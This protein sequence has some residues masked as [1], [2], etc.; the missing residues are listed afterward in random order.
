MRGV[1]LLLL[2]AGLVFAEGRPAFAIGAGEALDDPVLEER[3]REI[4][5]GLRCLVCQNQSIDDSD[6][7]LAKDLRRLVRERL[8]AGDSDEQVVDYIVAR[9]GDFVLLKPPF[10]SKT[11]LLWI[12]P[13]AI[14]LIAGIGGVVSLRRQNRAP[15]T[16]VPLSDEER[17]RLDH[18]ID[19]TE[20]TTWDAP[21]GVTKPS[22]T[23]SVGGAKP[24]KTIA[25]A[26]LTGDA[27]NII[28]GLGIS[29]K[30]T[31]LPV[32]AVCRGSQV[33]NVARGP[34]MPRSVP[35]TLAVYP[36]RKWY[37]APAGVRRASGGRPPKASAVGPV[38]DR[39]TTTGR[40]VVVSS[41]WPRV[42][43][44]ARAARS[45]LRAGAGAP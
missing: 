40:R 14:L 32:L 18:L 23:I 36:E 21:T 17:R 37:I 10:K 24:V 9:Y 35:A 3:A 25:N 39:T 45:W 16:A 29:M 13:A 34:V 8:V 20:G 33:L 22:V 5:K 30:A 28:A 42:R 12:G 15:Q 7:D 1:A 31:A 26:S 11:L 19:D 4:G 43:S 6:A 27:T 2:A 44:R 38:D 41:S